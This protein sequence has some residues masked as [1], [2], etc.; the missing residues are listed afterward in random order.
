MLHQIGPIESEAAPA[1]AFA[2]VMLL[3]GPVDLAGLLASRSG[4]ASPLNVV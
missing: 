2:M 3:A 1:A 4:T